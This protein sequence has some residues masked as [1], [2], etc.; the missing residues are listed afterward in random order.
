MIFQNFSQSIGF[1][2][3]QLIV[4]QRKIE[5]IEREKAIIRQ[6][7]IDLTKLKEEENAEDIR[8]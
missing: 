7:I 3:K 5:D 4:L 8:I 6:T 2:K 1:Y